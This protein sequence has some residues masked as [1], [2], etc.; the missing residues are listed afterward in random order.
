M[1]TIRAVL[2]RKGSAV[3]TVRREQTV[4]R[5]ISKMAQQ[6]VGSLVVLDDAGVCGIV[7]ERDYLRKVTLQQRSSQSTRI[8]EIM[9]TPVL[10]VEPS[11]SVD[12]ALA[13]MTRERCRHLPV[14]NSRGLAG[15]VSIGDLVR[16]GV[17]DLKAEVKHLHDYIG[18]RYPG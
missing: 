14:V 1:P 6:N 15:L 18:G 5:A 9:S 16:Q 10:C 2:E 8:E 12:H 13:I 7:T 3:Y 4:F 11:D 17:H